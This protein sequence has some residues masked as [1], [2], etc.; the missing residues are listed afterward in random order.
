MDISSPEILNRPT[1]VFIPQILF[2]LL[3]LGRSKVYTSMILLLLLLL[4]ADSRS[5]AFLRLD[6]VYVQILK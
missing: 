2:F 1:S 6:D 3:Q 4:L 5:Y